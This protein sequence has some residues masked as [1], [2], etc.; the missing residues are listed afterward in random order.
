[1]YSLNLRIKPYIQPFERKLA[2]LEVERLANSLPEPI[3]HTEIDKATV[4]QVRS[5]LP[6]EDLADRI[7]YWEAITLED[8]VITTQQVQREST[9]SL[10]RNGKSLSDIV[11]VT[12]KRDDLLS[13]PNRRCLRYGSH[14]LHEYRGKFFPQL[15]RSLINIAELPPNAI[16]GDPMCGSGTTAVEAVLAGHTAQVVDLNPLSVFMTQTKCDVLSLRPRQ[17]DKAFTQ[18]SETLRRARPSEAM[19]YTEEL[20]DADKEYLNRWMPGEVLSA[21]DTIF[22]AISDLRDPTLRN[23]FKLCQSNILRRAS[24]QK[25]ADLRV[26]KDASKNRTFREVVDLFLSEAESNAKYT[27]AFLSRERSRAGRCISFEGDARELELF[28]ARTC[29]A[30][31]TSPP[32]ATALPYL[33]TDRLSLIYLGLLSRSRHRARDQK[34]IGNRE[35]TEKTRRELWESFERGDVSIPEEGLRVITEIYERNR[36]DAKAGFRRK[37]LPPLLYQ[38]FRDMSVTMRS[39]KARMTKGAACF[40]VVGDNQTTAGGKKIRI[41]TIRILQRIA[42]REGFDTVDVLPMEMLI[43]REIHRKNATPSESIIWIRNV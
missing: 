8:Q 33:D 19:P 4:Y 10:A 43:N 38:Y 18:V 14:G 11:G 2:L 31:I 16:V 36:K 22:L 37:N 15:V 41:P 17:L 9:V 35:I 20:Q 23:F 25:D 12:P 40:V 3:D 42:E 21:L 27:A 32:Y 26:R 6:A 34:M 24:W 1:M 13:A 39:M 30:V 5:V 7:A 28:W 29:D